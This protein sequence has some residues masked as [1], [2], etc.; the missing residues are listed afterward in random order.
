MKGNDVLTQSGAVVGRISGDRVF[1]DNGAGVPGE[2]VG[3][4]VG[5]RLVYRSFDSD[6]PYRPFRRRATEIRLDSTGRVAPSKLWGDE[7]TLQG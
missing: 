1:R 7:P 6:G 4:V 5:D 3:T 2:Y